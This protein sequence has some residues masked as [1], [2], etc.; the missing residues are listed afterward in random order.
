MFDAIGNSVAAG[1]SHDC[2]VVVSWSHLFH[3]AGLHNSLCVCLYMCIL[4][5]CSIIHI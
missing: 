4:G 3:R 5:E 2:G 1:A